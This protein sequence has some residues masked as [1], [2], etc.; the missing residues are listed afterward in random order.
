[1]TK[2]KLTTPYI[3]TDKK[4]RVITSEPHDIIDEGKYILVTIKAKI[5]SEVE[6]E[7]LALKRPIKEKFDSRVMILKDT[8]THVE[9]FFSNDL[10]IYVTNIN[11]GSHSG[12]SFGMES[13]EKAE[14]LAN[15]IMEMILN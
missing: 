11:Y 12:I 3:S 15:D 9:S 13:K 5:E 6:D 7:D 1:M 8:I 4:E 2:R 14:K 10:E